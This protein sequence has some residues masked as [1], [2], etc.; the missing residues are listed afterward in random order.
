MAMQMAEMM[1][2]RYLRT[3]IERRMSPLAASNWS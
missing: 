2:L 1:N 3:E